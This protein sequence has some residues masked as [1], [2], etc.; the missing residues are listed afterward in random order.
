MMRMPTVPGVCFALALY[1][2]PGALQQFR[3]NGMAADFS[4]DQTAKR[5]LELYHQ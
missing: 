2:A 4:W 3:L 1:D 5:Y